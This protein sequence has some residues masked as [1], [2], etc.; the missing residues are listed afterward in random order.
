MLKMWHI[1]YLF[2]WF[3]FKFFIRKNTNNETPSKKRDKKNKKPNKNHD[4]KNKK[5]YKTKNKKL[6]V[7][8]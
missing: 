2:V 7:D 4:K 6:S 5:Q 8:P 3:C 1:G